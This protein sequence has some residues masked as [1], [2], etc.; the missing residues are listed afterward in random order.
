[1]TIVVLGVLLG[2]QLAGAQSNRQRVIPIDDDAYTYLDLVFLESGLARPSAFR[3]YSAAEFD[4]YIA[5]VPAD[6][7]SPYGRELLALLEERLVTKQMVNNESGLGFSAGVTSSI[8]Y[9]NKTDDASDYIFSRGDRLPMLSVPVEFWFFD[10]VYATSELT[11]KE[12]Y[13][14]SGGRWEP[15][16]YTRQETDPPPVQS[17]S[18]N[19]FSTDVNVLELDW[20][21]PT[22]ALLSTGGE[23]WRLTYGRDS[24]EMGTGE[25]GTLL[26]SDFPDYYDAISLS[27]NWRGWKGTASYIY[28]EPWLT[29]SDL[30]R[31]ASGEYFMRI[32]DYGDPYKA[33]FV[34]HLEFR[35]LVNLPRLP[36][37]MFFLSEALLFGSQYPQIRDFNPFMVFHNWF[38]YERSNDTL[39]AGFSLVPIPR[40]ELYGEYFLNEFDTEYEGGNNFPGAAGWLGGLRGM[41]ATPIGVFTGYA[42]YVHTDPLLYN[43][44]HPLLKFV[45]RRRIWSYIEPDQMIYVDKP[46]GYFTGPDANLA[47]IGLG[48]MLA[49]Q[50][51][52]QLKYSYIAKGEKD[53]ESAYVEVPGETTPT[54]IPWLTHVIELS[55]NYTPRPFAEVGGSVFFVFDTNAEHQSGVSRSDVQVALHVTLSADPQS[56]D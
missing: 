27:T 54:G 33:L 52:A 13:R 25:T 7:L 3:P 22:R 26:L 45:S 34:H 55:A 5:L 24:M 48:Y 39:Y 6:R 29:A 17:N 56:L 40:V 9:Y 16:T 15:I 2:L 42:E 20:Y 30:S 37:F 10:S 51:E 36:Q 50:V 8:E 18:W 43:R 1:M 47:S 19:W 4:E 49:P 44:Y 38:E 32:R 28:L 35:P 21:F 53:T 14:L 23:H 31:I 11:L 46:T 12:D 41:L